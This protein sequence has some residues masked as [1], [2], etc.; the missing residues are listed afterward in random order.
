MADD[1]AT[2]SGQ[3]PPGDK[4]TLRA[5]GQSFLASRTALRSA[6]SYFSA[7]FDSGMREASSAEIEMHDIEPETLSALVD[8]SE[9]RPISVIENNVAELLRAGVL[10]QFDQVTRACVSYVYKKL[11]VHSAVRAWQL[12]DAYSISQLRRSALA[13][14]MWHFEEFVDSPSLPDCPVALFRRLLLKERLN[15]RNESIVYRGV[16]IWAQANVDACSHREFVELM[17]CVRA[18]LLR[19]DQRVDMYTQRTPEGTPFM[20]HLPLDFGPKNRRRPHIGAALVVSKVGPSDQIPDDELGL[21]VQDGLHTLKLRTL[22]PAR[23]RKPLQGYVVCNVGC[24]V[25]F[26]CGEFGVGSGNWHRD[27]WKWDSAASEWVNI[28]TNPAPRRHCKVAVVG[29]RIYL[30]GGYGR[31]RVPMTSIDFFDTS[32]GRWHVAPGGPVRSTPQAVVASESVVYVVFGECLVSVYDTEKSVMIETPYTL[33]GWAFDYPDG[34]VFPEMVPKNEGRFRVFL[35]DSEFSWCN[36]FLYEDSWKCNPPGGGCPLEFG[37]VFVYKSSYKDWR[38]EGA[39]HTV[40]EAHVQ[41]QIRLGLRPG[42]KIEGCVAVPGFDLGP[43][44]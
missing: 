15:V 9:G 42:I 4:V 43:D 34:S 40:G 25:Y 13:V 20:C 22:L 12:G 26:L 44:D 38:N 21:F 33:D 23:S 7:M 19:P 37:S 27:V 39:I 6:S 36:T 30:F 2:T 29:S 5:C 24:A 35:P 10:F 16:M 1:I 28:G 18:S 8:S 32:T 41:R 17:L 14:L 31:Y 3:R 11:T